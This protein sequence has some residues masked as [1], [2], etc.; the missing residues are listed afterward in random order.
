ME[1]QVVASVERGPDSFWDTYSRYYDSIYHLMPYRE[2]LWDAYQALD[3]QPGMRLLDAG[4]GTGNFECFLA[5]KNAPAASIHAIDLSEGMLARAR[6]KCADMPTVYLECA[7]LNSQLPFEDA[8]FDRIVSINVLYALDDPD[9]A[10]GEF[11]RVLKPEGRIVL[12]TPLPE[13]RIGPLVVDHF[14]RVRNIWGVGRKVARVVRS[15]ALL[16]TSGLAQAFLSVTVINGREASGQYRSL[17]H[18]DLEE[19]LTRRR[20]E[21]LSEISVGPALVQQSVFATA[22]KALPA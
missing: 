10:I 8:S 17:S 6:R 21:G 7:N 2:L 16:V 20:A 12:S 4:C 1:G 22:M 15:L 13:F 9:H 5:E 19:L 3:L 18:D 11:L 14:R